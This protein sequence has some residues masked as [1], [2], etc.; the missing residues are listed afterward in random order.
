LTVEAVRILVH[1]FTPHDPNV[2]LNQAASL[3][4]AVAAAASGL[5]GPG[6]PSAP[7][8][9]PHRLLYGAEV[10]AVALFLIGMLHARRFRESVFGVLAAAGQGLRAAL[11]DWPARALPWA[12]I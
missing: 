11:I 2:H 10:L 5:H 6:A 7:S 8:P 4:T 1:L 12:S 3:A 9:W